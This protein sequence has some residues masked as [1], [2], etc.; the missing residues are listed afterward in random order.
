[1]VNQRALFIP[2]GA[3]EGPTFGLSKSISALPLEP[4][5]HG[6]G[7]RLGLLSQ[8]GPGTKLVVCGEGFDDRTVKVRANG[9]CYFVFSQDIA[10]STKFSKAMA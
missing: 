9:T 8:L 2:E 1:M 5:E 3:V 10:S 6:N 7:A 4:E